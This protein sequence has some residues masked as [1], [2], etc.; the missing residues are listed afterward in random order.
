MKV[1]SLLALLSA[2]FVSCSGSK[3]E[4]ASADPKTTA[5]PKPEKKVEELPKLP[6][7]RLPGKKKNPLFVDPPTHDDLM[8]E[9]QKKTVLELPTQPVELP[10]QEGESGI[11]AAPPIPTP[12]PLKIEVN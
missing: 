4:E 12:P 3:P 10:E 1:L 5:E 11:I 9:D 7:P 8:T 2:L 6:T